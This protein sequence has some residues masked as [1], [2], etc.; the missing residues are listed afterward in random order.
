MSI[1]NPSKKA[2]ELLERFEI[3]AIPVPVESIARK[4]DA[5]VR[6]VP[7]DDELSGMIYVNDETPIIGV[8]SIH[9]IHRQRF[10]IAHEIGHL[11]LHYDRV[12]EKVHVDKRFRVAIYYNRDTQSSHGTEL[13]E[14]QANQFAAALLMPET[15]LRSVV[16]GRYDIDDDGPIE[17]LSRRLRVSRQ[18]L[19]FRIR[20]LR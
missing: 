15:Y 1:P 7:L 17:S 8:N 10:T 6:Y 5:I 9:H 2:A 16:S 13:V 11:V 3:S 20:S 19:E 18:A 4:L 14:I 12:R